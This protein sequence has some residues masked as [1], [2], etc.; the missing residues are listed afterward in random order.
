MTKKPKPKYYVVWEGKVPGIYSTW[1]ECLQQTK[2]FPKAKY[3]GFFTRQS[4]EEAL[5]DGSSKHWGTGRSANEVIIPAE[6]RLLIGD[7]ILE[8]ISVDAA[9]NTGTGVVEYQGVNTKTKEV[10]FKEGPYSDGTINLGEFIAVVHGLAHCKRHGLNIPIYTDS[11]VAMSWVRDKVMRSDHP[12]SEANIRLYKIVDHALSWLKE[13][14]YPNKIL[15][16]ETKFW[17]EN[18]ADFGRK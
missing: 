4:A 10:I 8:S 7:P 6:Q 9:W 11:A 2:G 1:D 18:P 16:W 15:K 17:G 3:K 13:N 14:E 12:R 5:K